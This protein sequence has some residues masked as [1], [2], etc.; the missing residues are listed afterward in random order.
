MHQCEVVPAADSA[1]EAA[2]SLR[3]DNK[4]DGDDLSPAACDVAAASAS[5]S[6][7]MHCD[8]AAASASTSPGMHC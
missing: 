4:G 7:G 6:P 8:V 1:A 3:L 5:T 2:A